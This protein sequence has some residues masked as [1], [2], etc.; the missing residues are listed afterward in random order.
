MAEQAWPRIYD[1]RADVFG[2]HEGREKDITLAAN[3]TAR[4]MLAAAW[5]VSESDLTIYL[6]ASWFERQPGRAPRWVLTIRYLFQ[7]ARLGAIPN[8]AIADAHQAIIAM[9]QRA[10]VSIEDHR[11]EVAS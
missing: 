9:A 7:P 3:P 8:E 5:E 2:V 1:H 4:A 6:L 11:S 10:G